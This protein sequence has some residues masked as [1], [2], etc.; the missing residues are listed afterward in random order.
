MRFSPRTL[1]VCLL[2]AITIQSRA[3]VSVAQISNLM[4]P[5]T[6]GGIGDIH[7]VTPNQRFGFSFT[8]GASAT[9]LDSVVLEHYAYPGTLQ[10]FGVELYRVD[11]FSLFGTVSVTFL[12]TLGNSA[13]DP[14]PTQWPGDTTFVRY[15]SATSLLLESGTSYMIAAIEPPEGSNETGILFAATGNGYSTPGDWTTSPPNQFFSDSTSPWMISFQPGELKIEI[16]AVPIPEPTVTSVLALSASCLLG[17]R[18]VKRA[19]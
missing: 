19:N 9:Q 14:R 2:L 10:S 15:A 8:T 4:V 18:I 12:G 11:E 7:P 6:G 5:W 13:I 1:G 16:N 3:T 17:R